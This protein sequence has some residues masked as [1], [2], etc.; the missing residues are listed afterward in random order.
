MSQLRHRGWILVQARFFSCRFSLK[1]LTTV[2]NVNFEIHCKRTRVCK[3]KRII[4]YSDKSNE[5]QGAWTLL[6]VTVCL[7][8]LVHTHVMQIIW[9]T[10]FGREM[11]VWHVVIYLSFITKELVNGVL[12]QMVFS[13]K[14]TVIITHHDILI[15]MMANDTVICHCITSNYS[16]CKKPT[17]VYHL[18]FRWVHK[19]G[20]VHD[21]FQS[22]GSFWLVE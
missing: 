13:E 3:K 10:F 22:F 11:S 19:D 16:M 18:Q 14:C 9:M 1:L 4:Y 12:I 20:I 7:T 8:M 5:F 17:E 6:Q 2:I 21:N 15:S